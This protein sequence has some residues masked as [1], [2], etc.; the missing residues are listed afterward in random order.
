MLL[1]GGGE[2]RHRI[3]SVV[4]S[5]QYLKRSIHVNV[6]RTA[7]EACVAVAESVRRDSTLDLGCFL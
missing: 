1:G 2:G 3:A 5:T 4:Y 7:W 6:G